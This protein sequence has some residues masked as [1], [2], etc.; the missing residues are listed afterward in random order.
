MKTFRNKLIIFLAVTIGG[1]IG[2]FKGEE[3]KQKW[4]FKVRTKYENK[5]LM[6]EKKSIARKGGVMLDDIEMAAYHDN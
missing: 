1:V 2:L 3:A 4:V 6:A 5:R